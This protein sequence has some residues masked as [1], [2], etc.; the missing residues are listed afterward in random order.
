MTA[1]TETSTTLAHVPRM[2]ALGARLRTE[3]GKVAALRSTW[4]E[5]LYRALNLPTRKD[6]AE[7]SARLDELEARLAKRV[8]AEKRVRKK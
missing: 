6:I 8:V 2:S 3:W 1:A 7:L 4:A 5:K